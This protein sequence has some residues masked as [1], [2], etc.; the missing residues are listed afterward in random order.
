M[1]Y[2]FYNCS[3]LEYL[4]FSNFNIQ[5]VRNMDDI[6]KYCDSLKYIDISN[7]TLSTDRYEYFNFSDGCQIRINNKTKDNIITNCEIIISGN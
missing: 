7:F 3:S 4:D 1:D 5:N 6:F 2:M